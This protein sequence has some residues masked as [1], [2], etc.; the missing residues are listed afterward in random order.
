MYTSDILPPLRLLNM[1]SHTHGISREK[2]KKKTSP[3]QAPR[4]DLVGWNQTQLVSSRTA[5]SPA[6]QCNAFFLWDG[7]LDPGMSP[8][9]SVQV[10]PKARQMCPCTY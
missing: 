10:L 9:G 3:G 7:F 8:L 6:R 4:K 2:Q 1:F 5:L